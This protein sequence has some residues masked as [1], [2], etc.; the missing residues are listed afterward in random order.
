LKGIQRSDEVQ[1]HNFYPAS[2]TR[3]ESWLV[4]AKMLGEKKKKGTGTW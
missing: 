2:Q 1:Q 4:V 3:S